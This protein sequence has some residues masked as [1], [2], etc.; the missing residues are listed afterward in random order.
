MMIIAQNDAMT[1][2]RSR[3]LSADSG[4]GSFFLY[5]A[6]TAF[7]GASSLLLFCSSPFAPASVSVGVCEDVDMAMFFW[8]SHLVLTD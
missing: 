4:G 3:M 2:V 5:A 1:Q 6:L 7:A 8:V